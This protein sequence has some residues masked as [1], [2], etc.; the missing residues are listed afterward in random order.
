MNINF[1][2][3]NI[4]QIK[5]FKPFLAAT[6][7]PLYDKTTKLSR[8]FKQRLLCVSVLASNGFN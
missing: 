8:K 6:W 4:F 1:V 2:F 5:K 3:M 7:C